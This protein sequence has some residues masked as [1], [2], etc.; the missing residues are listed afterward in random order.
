MLRK[1]DIIMNLIMYA[2]IW[3]FGGILDESG[4]SKYN[5][6]IKTLFTTN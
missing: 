1:E 3:N 5:E 2:L 4:R 6:F